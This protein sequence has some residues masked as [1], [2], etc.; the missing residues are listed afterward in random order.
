MDRDRPLLI[1]EMGRICG[2]H[3]QAISI[4]HTQFPLNLMVKHH[5]PHE[6]VIFYISMFTASHHI[7][8][9]IPIGCSMEIPTGGERI[10]GC[11]SRRWGWCW[12]SDQQPGLGALVPVM[13]T[14]MRT[15]QIGWFRMKEGYKQRIGM[16]ELYRR[17]S[18]TDIIYHIITYYIYNT[19]IFQ[20]PVRNVNNINYCQ[21]SKITLGTCRRGSWKDQLSSPRKITGSPKPER[22]WA[23]AQKCPSKAC[24]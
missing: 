23:G 8:R 3:R 1:W 15:Y 19:F 14:G 2:S 24:S 11:P 12:A 7:L 9:D 4:T 18:P 10:S 20:L 5:I 22:P 17:I 21:N 6:T 16:S 13:G